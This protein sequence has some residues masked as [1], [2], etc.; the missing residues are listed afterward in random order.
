MAFDELEHG[1]DGL[2]QH[3]AALFGAPGRVSA[4]EFVRVTSSAALS[5][6][7]WPA[8]VAAAVASDGVTID[9]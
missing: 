8:R 6:T 3:F 2:L 9:G 7:N 4:L 5:P 1:N